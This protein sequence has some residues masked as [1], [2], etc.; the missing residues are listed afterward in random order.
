LPSRRIHFFAPAASGRLLIE[1]LNLASGEELLIHLRDIIGPNYMVTGD[2]ALIE[3]GENELRGGRSD[4][5]ERAEEIER[6]LGNDDVV[7]LVALRGGAWLTRILPRIDF[8]VLDRRITRVAVIGFSEMTTLVNIV[9]A[10][11]N[12]L[13][14]YDMSPG[15]LA[16][17]LK[18][19]AL[20][21]EPEL[22]G[23]TTPDDW[24]AGRMREEFARYVRHIIAMVEGRE[25]VSPIVAR[26]VRGA[27]PEQMEATFLG[28]NLTVFSTLIGSRYEADLHPAGKWLML[29]DFNDKLERLDRFLA[30]ITL[31]G[32][33]ERCEGVLLGDFHQGARDLTGPV[34]DLLDRHVATTQSLPVLVA[35]TI[36]HVWPMSPLPLHQPLRLRR[37]DVDSFLIDWPSELTGVV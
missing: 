26:L 33:W 35:S 21:H 25:T 6:A 19:H 22:T 11:R 13:G 16:Y 29:E 24:V 10:H 14:I 15:F 32:Y 31:A 5:A 17:G 18:R 1:K 8:S 9:G 20:R 28:G 34:L 4:D 2:P 12:G 27:M 7:A 23:E 3:A 30:H 36:G 37:D